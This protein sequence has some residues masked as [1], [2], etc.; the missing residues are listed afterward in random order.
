MHQVPSEPRVRLVAVTSMTASVL[1][2]S[3]PLAASPSSAVQQTASDAANVEAV[4]RRLVEADNAGD[5]EGVLAGYADDAV[6]LPPGRPHVAG[7]EAIREHYA[8]LFR[9]LRFEV[10][11]DVAEVVVSGDLAYVRGETRGAVIAR[12]DEGRTPVHDDYL[13]VLRRSPDGAWRITRLIWNAAA[14]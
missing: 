1:L 14:S 3:G 7:H 8:A 13:M 2:I 11:I 4:A 9:D 12:R 10:E 5:L 6:L